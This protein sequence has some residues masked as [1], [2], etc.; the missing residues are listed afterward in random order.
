MR[1]DKYN[2]QKLQGVVKGLVEQNGDR[3]IDDILNG[4]ILCIVPYQSAT[5]AQKIDALLDHLGLE[6]VPGPS[7][8]V[9]KKAK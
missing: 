6:T 7:V 1:I 5:S 4:D 9:Q 8:I 2:W 3:H